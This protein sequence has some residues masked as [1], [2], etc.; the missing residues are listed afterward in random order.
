L[1]DRRRTSDVYG[2]NFCWSE[3]TVVSASLKVSL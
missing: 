2:S 1:L 3:R